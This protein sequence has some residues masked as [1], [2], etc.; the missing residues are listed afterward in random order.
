MRSCCL[1]IEGTG[2]ERGDALHREPQPVHRG[3]RALGGHPSTRGSGTQRKPYRSTEDPG[4][5]RSPTGSG[6]TPDSGEAQL[7]HSGPWFTWKPY[8]STGGPW[9]RMDACGTTGEP[10]AHVEA[11]PAPGSPHAIPL[12]SRGGHTAVPDCAD[13]AT[14]GTQRRS[15]SSFKLTAVKFLASTNQ[16][17]RRRSKEPIIA[18]IRWGGAAWEPGARKGAETAAGGKEGGRAPTDS[19]SC[20]PP[21]V[22]LLFL[23]SLIY[24]FF[25]LRSF[26]FCLF[27]GPFSSY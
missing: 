13:V 17:S 5:R 11:L 24:F 14:Q 7:A 15:A 16:I 18:E 2:L 23:D 27:L 1:S 19:K 22:V 3:L 26:L 12:C 8:R 6:G 25:S 10:R 9:A 20:F 4:L 21:S